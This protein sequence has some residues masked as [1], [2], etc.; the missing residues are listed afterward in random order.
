[1]F[2]YVEGEA[3]LL[4]TNNDTNTMRLYGVPSRSPWVKD[5]FHHRVIE[6]DSY[7]FV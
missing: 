7:N 5:A 4:F 1:M 3:E 2:F 6:G